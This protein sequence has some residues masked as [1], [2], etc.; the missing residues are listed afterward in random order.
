MDA[1]VWLRLTT[2][3]GYQKCS[4]L[5]ELTWWKSS[6]GARRTALLGIL[7]EKNQQM[8]KLVSAVFSARTCQTL[9]SLPD[10]LP[11]QKIWSKFTPR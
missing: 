11:F 2:P 9:K 3:I 10:A 1:F 4:A 6:P 5:L 7:E 8:A